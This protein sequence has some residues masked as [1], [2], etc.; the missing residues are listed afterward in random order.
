MDEIA[1]NLP[2]KFCKNSPMKELLFFVRKVQERNHVIAK[3][4]QDLYDQKDIYSEVYNI[5]NDNKPCKDLIDYFLL[6]WFITFH[7]LNDNTID[8]RKKEIIFDQ[9]QNISRGFIKNV[10]NRG[11]IELKLQFALQD[12]SSLDIYAKLFAFLVALYSYFYFKTSKLAISTL[13]FTFL[14]SIFENVQFIFIHNSLL[15]LK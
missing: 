11:K 2:I 15:K 7:I 3:Y 6:L 4:I 10:S 1:N 13:I 12:K 9:T 14:S 5:V 8:E